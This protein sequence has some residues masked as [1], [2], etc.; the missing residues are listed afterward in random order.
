ME[1]LNG[2]GATGQATTVATALHSDGF[3]INGTG[4]AANFGYTSNVIDYS[5]GQYAAALTLKAYLSGST[6]V[7]ESTSTPSPVVD[8]VLGATYDGLTNP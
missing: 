5:P 4:D 8:L 6:T 2:T 1:V 7:E 3:A